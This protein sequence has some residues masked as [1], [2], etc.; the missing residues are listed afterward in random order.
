MQRAKVSALWPQR[1]PVW[2]QSK[3]TNKCFPINIKLKSF[4]FTSS[5]LTFLN[6]RIFHFIKHSL[7]VAE[8]LLNTFH[9]KIFSVLLKIYNNQDKLITILRLTPDLLSNV[10]KM[11]LTTAWNSSL[12]RF[13][14]QSKQLKWHL[15]KPS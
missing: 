9:P 2:L 13:F 11:L 15:M 1:C 14:F 4:T 3:T 10:S 7:L 5:L 8:Y 12:Q 6:Y